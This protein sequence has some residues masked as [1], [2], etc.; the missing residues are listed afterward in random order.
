M[1]LHLL[2]L[3]LVLELLSLGVL[4]V[5]LLT[6]VLQLHAVAVDQE[7]PL[8]HLEVLDVERGEQL[9]ELDGL[10]GQVGVLLV[11]R[12][13]VLDLE[14]AD[15]FVEQVRPELA[16]GLGER[17]EVEADEEDPGEEEEEEAL[18]DVA[19]LLL[20][21]HLDHLLHEQVQLPLEVVVVAREDQEG[22]ALHRVAPLGDDGVVGDK[23]AALRVP[24][25]HLLL[26]DLV[27]LAVDEVLHD[28]LP[29]LEVEDAGLEE[30]V[31]VEELDDLAAVGLDQ[32]GVDLVRLLDHLREELRDELVHHVRRLVRLHRLV[33]VLQDLDGRQQDDLHRLAGPVRVPRALE[34]D[35]QLAEELLEGEHGVELGLAEQVVGVDLASQGQPD[36]LHVLG[37]GEVLDREGLPVLVE[38]LHGLEDAG[39]V[40]LA[41]P[42]VLVLE[43]LVHQHLE[44]RPVEEDGPIRVDHLALVHRLDH[45]PPLLH[46]E[47]EGRVVASQLTLH[48]ILGAEA[49]AHGGHVERLIYLMLE[50]DVLVA[51]EELVDCGGQGKVVGLCLV[52][53]DVELVRDDGGEVG[54]HVV[55]EVEVL[56]L[57]PVVQL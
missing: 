11:E 4:L 8:V 25:L 14:D 50:S 15:E 52:E 29:L 22:D 44:R 2:E 12:L 17:D 38:D 51:P 39:V 40:D 28:L 23:E 27:G 56:L 5:P 46:L 41:H 24:L 42:V 9:D 19:L 48:F 13:L 3:L 37:L 53:L 20:L 49:L 45:R 21:E 54:Q 43:L 31:H 32:A 6:L 36:L 10:D 33:V 30:G 16:E 1:L 35:E 26:E 34:V 18:L 7:D 55:K 57:H 47:L